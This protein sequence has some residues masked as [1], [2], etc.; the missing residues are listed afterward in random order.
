MRDANK[1]FVNPAV[2]DVL[3][4]AQAELG[5]AGQPATHLHG[6]INDT[7]IQKD[8]QGN[9]VAVIKVP[10]YNAFADTVQMLQR[11][12]AVV[13]AVQELEP[14]GV[15]V[16]KLLFSAADK[17]QPWAAFSFIPGH[18]FSR[19]EAITLSPAERIT[20]GAKVG[21][22]VA[23]LGIAFDCSTFSKKIDEPY[24][25]C[26]I[27]REAMVR[28]GI[29]LVGPI[30]DKGYKLFAARLAETGRSYH[31]FRGRGAFAA[32]I[33]G[34]DDLAPTN[35]AF[36]AGDG[37]YSLGVFDFAL[38][39][40]SNPEREL[41]FVPMLGVE[42]LHAACESYEKTSGVP[43]NEDVITLWDKM[44]TLGGFAT[45]LM[46]DFKATPFVL[47]DLHRTHPDID[48]Y[49]ELIRGEI[50]TAV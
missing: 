36:S 41:R 40:P 2:T 16:P 37:N 34:H 35:Y 19:E 47:L 14:I 12:V 45:A 26:G 8:G 9:P 29:K 25:A 5:Y 23:K 22:F 13:N 28:E 50:E 20:F 4:A 38:T 21:E 24:G 33:V 42:A 27:D 31:Y 39:K 6:S 15:A 17:E 11:E 49:E 43:V 48:W 30:H 32:T 46:K 18:A 3:G 7:F 44:S 10:H 1:E